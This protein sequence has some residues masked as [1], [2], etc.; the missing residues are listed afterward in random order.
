MK[1]KSEL[2][3]KLGVFSF[4]SFLVIYLPYPGPISY[5]QSRLS[6]TYRTLHPL[7]PGS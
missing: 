2:V 6:Y 3:N 4:S 5:L 1:K 7:T